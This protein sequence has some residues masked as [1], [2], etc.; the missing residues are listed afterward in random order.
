VEKEVLF[1]ASLHKHC[2]VTVGLLQ[3][4]KRY[5]MKSSRLFDGLANSPLS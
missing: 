1:T 2:S 4:S 5:I 3:Y